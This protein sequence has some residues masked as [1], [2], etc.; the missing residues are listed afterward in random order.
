MTVLVSVNGEP[1]RLPDGATITALV[2]SLAS[3]SDG[4]GIAVALDDE[5]VPRREWSTTGL[6]DGARV[7]VLTAVQG[8]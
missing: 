8:G 3:N 1:R 7:E 4:R 5:V 6:P 2:Q